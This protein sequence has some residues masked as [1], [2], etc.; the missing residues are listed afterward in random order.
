MSQFDLWTW[1]Y[2]ASSLFW[3]NVF[4][5]TFIYYCEFIS[6]LELNYLIFKIKEKLSPSWFQ[7]AQ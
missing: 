6:V 2:L 7:Q 5:W 3:A 1:V 4:F